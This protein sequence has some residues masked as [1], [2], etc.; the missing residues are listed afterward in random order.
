MRCTLGLALLLIPAL[1]K[2][3]AGVILESPNEIEGATT[4]EFGGH[5]DP[6]PNDPNHPTLPDPINP[7]PP[8]PDPGETKEEGPE[9]D[10]ANALSKILKALTSLI[11]LESHS[12]TRP[13][14]VPLPTAAQPCISARN[15][16]YSCASRAS[17]S[18]ATAPRNQPCIT[19]VPGLP[20]AQ[21]PSGPDT[22]TAMIQSNCLCYHSQDQE[23]SSY[24]PGLF[25]G[26]LSSC[27]DYVQAQTK[28]AAR[29]SLAIATAFCTSAGNANVS[30]TPAASTTASQTTPSPTKS[31]ATVLSPVMSSGSWHMVWWTV[32][33]LVRSGW[34]AFGHG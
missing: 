10:I 33:V 26:Y 1:L 18:Y 25:D 15:R 12:T 34:A 31:A 6:E 14:S 28:L 11:S 19:I 17:S 4:P 7:H 21:G 13:S 29:S 5:P 30:P 22:A 27:N 3:A 16:F 8:N 20:C 32:I 9:G 24:A 2:N 23:T